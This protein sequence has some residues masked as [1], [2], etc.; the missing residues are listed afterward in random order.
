MSKLIQVIVVTGLLGAFAAA[1]V[2]GQVATGDR[3]FES[4]AEDVRQQLDESLAEL[5][6]LREAIAAEKL[7]LGRTLNELEGELAQVRQEFQEVSRLLDTRTL[8]LSNLRNEIKLRRDEGSYLQ[9]LLGEYVR[10]FESRLHIAEVQRY[11]Q[12]LEA[13]KLAAEN[14]RLSDQ[15]VFAA[16]SVLLAESL[17]RLH[18]ALGGTRFDGS[19]VDAEGIVKPGRFAM[20]GPAVLFQSEDQQSIGTAEQRLG[21]L[22]PTVVAFRDPAESDAAKQF[23]D[24]AGKVFLL[25]PTLGNAHAIEAT[26]ETLREHLEKGG[27]VMVPILLLAAVSLIV[28]LA[29]WVSMSMI[30]R[31][32][33]QKIRS[34]MDDVANGDRRAVE[35]TAKSVGG[36]TGQMLVAG[37]EHIDEPRE[38]IEEVMYEHVLTARLNLQR[39]LPFIAV[40]AASAPLLGL[41]GTVTGIINTFK[42]ITVFGTGDVKTLSSGISEAL[43]T[44]EWGLIVAIPSLL[45]HAMLSRKAKR[46][47]DEMEKAAVALINQVSKTPFQRKTIAGAG[48]ETTAQFEPCDADRTNPQVARAATIVRSAISNLEDKLNSDDKHAVEVALRRLNESAAELA[49]AVSHASGPAPTRSSAERVSSTPA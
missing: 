14:S 44:T 8:D 42:L 48:G 4:A 29:K 5:T 45:L 19:A 13:A 40:A 34:L 49:A 39:L 24:G 28:A 31:P 20:I 30:A 43:I 25:D 23:I 17:E 41:L 11:R 15:E 2:R 10:N 36:M 33:Q 27:P 6:R 18:D 3:P 26:R 46:I 35:C 16:Q 1:A 12:S 47:V 21:S 22:E 38:L 7:P 37:I 32:S 9:N